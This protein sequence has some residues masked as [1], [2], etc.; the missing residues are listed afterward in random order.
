MELLQYFKD[1]PI[2]ISFDS[3]EDC[4][5]IH[6]IFKHRSGWHPSKGS[7]S[8]WIE[9]DG[10]VKTSYRCTSGDYLYRSNPYINISSD[11]F[12]NLINDDFT[13]TI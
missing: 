12:F 13:I 7:V 11:E 4:I 3:K 8:F 5:K 2:S 6:D 10:K 1:N 9:N